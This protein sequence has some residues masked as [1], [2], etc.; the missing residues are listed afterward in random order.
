MMMLR[1]RTK[2]MWMVSNGSDTFLIAYWGCVDDSPR[3]PDEWVA[4]ISGLNIGSTL[5]PDALVQLLVEYLTGEGPFGEGQLEPAQITRL[6]IAGNSMIQVTSDASDDITDKQ[7]V[8]FLPPPN[9]HIF[10]LGIQRKHD[11]QR[12]AFSPHPAVIFAQHLRDLAAV[13]PIHLLPGDRDPAGV[14]LPQQ[15][16]PRGLFDGLGSYESFYC[17]TNPTYISLGKDGNK[18]TRR[19][20]LVNSGQPLNDMFKY[21]LPSNH[22]KIN[23][24]ESTLRWRHIAPTAPDTLWCHPYFTD[25]PFIIRETPDIYIVGGQKKFRTKLV[26]DKVSG[27]RCRIVMVPEFWRSPIVVLI[28]LRTLAVRTIALDLDEMA[29]NGKDGLMRDRLAR[30]AAAKQKP[31]EIVPL[32]MQ[33]AEDGMEM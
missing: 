31:P 9:I 17:E 8:C 26:T 33:D 4:T 6:I 32:E 20:I 11:L 29:G 1:V 22:K 25:D 10:T 18:K 23:M 27:G 19:T 5:C 3:E 15:P 14:I 12:K 2:W 7:A 13:M 30:E 21:V 24:L 16:F 28:N